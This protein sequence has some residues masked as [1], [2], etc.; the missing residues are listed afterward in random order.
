VTS[1]RSRG[2][3]YDVNDLLISTTA[4]LHCPA[5]DFYIDPWQ[6]VSRAIVTHAHADH[7]S[8]GSQEYLASTDGR[9]VLQS[10]LGEQARIR[11]IDYGERLSLGDTTISLHPAGHILGSS[12]VRIERGGE[13]WVVTGDYKTAADATCM[14]FEPLRC[15]TLITESTFGLPIYRWQESA[16]IFAR[17]NAWWRTNAAAGVASI[18]YAYSLGKAQRILSGLDPSIG[19]IFC[20]GAVERLNDVYRASGVALPTTTYT[21][22]T[23][24]KRDWGGTLVIAPT[25]ARRSPWL[26]RFGEFSS[27]FASGWMQIRGARRRRAVDRGFALSDHADWPA[28]VDVIRASRAQRVLVTHGSIDPMV[29]WLNENGWQAAPLH[30]EFR[31]ELDESAEPGDALAGE[32]EPVSEAEPAP[33]E[34]LDSGGE[35]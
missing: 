18:L 12:Q 35:L 16:A 31:G 1:P 8:P 17:M 24:E 23:A 2:T 11:T 30:T 32:S 15:D 3:G 20:H 14:P 19:P 33:R 28:L 7:A 21:G 26:R 25:S 13:L 27:A 9:L 4:G 34:R 6:P 29:R 5:G 22:R 10:R